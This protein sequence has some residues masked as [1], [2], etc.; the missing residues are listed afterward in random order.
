[1]IS[2]GSREFVLVYRSSTHV[3]A[4]LWRMDGI[5][6]W[7]MESPDCVIT[8][9]I[10]KAKR[11]SSWQKASL[12]VAGHGWIAFEPVPASEDAALDALTDPSFTFPTSPSEARSA[13]P[14]M[15]ILW[16]EGRS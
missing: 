14:G 7:S 15:P 6:P 1:M 10:G 4:Y 11:F 5:G 16:K 9:D 8:E 2:H 12:H 13:W 3:P